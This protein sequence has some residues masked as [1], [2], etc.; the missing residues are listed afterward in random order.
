MQRESEGST[1]GG[2]RGRSS[3]E[4]LPPVKRRAIQGE[5]PRAFRLAAAATTP[6]GRRL[7]RQMPLYA[8]RC[9]YMRYISLYLAISRYISLY[10]AISR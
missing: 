1:A 6:D 3:V 2:R 10:P 9:L 7:F 8:A 4:R 5:T